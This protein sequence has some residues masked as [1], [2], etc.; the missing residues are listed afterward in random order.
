MELY[1]VGS[2]LSHPSY[3]DGVVIKLNPE[4]YE[5]CFMTYGI[6][7]I[8]KDYDRFSEIE[9]IEPSEEVSF[10]DAEKS[11]ARILQQWMGITELVPLGDKWKG[12]IMELKPSNPSLKSKEMPIESFFHKIVMLRDRLRVM[13]QRINSHDAFSDED[14]VNMQ[15]YITRIYGSLTS[16]NVLFKYPEHQFVGEKSS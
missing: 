12:G 13:E 6:K 15:Q 10:S 8:S 2:R 4:N 11:L 7:Q 9:R 5:I 1:G 16:F 14:K 3:G